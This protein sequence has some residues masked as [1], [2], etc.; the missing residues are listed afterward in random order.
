VD[1]RF[2]GF[3]HGA[4]IGIRSPR[5]PFQKKSGKREM[6]APSGSTRRK[7]RIGEKPPPGLRAAR[8]PNRAGRKNLC[9]QTRAVEA[10]CRHQKTGPLNG[11]TRRHAG[12]TPA[13]ALVSSA[14]GR[15]R[16]SGMGLQW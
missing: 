2:P 7:I 11:P 13:G 14:T 15:G 8:G 1:V 6:V 12:H 5:C 3:N 10:R 9:M 16:G 4:N